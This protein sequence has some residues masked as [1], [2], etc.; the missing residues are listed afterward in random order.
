M[1]ARL[2]ALVFVAGVIFCVRLAVAQELTPV[3][4]SSTLSPSTRD[5]LTKE[6]VKAL[7]EIPT[8]GTA[9]TQKE[10]RALLSDLLAKLNVETTC[11][12]QAAVASAEENKDAQ[13][14]TCSHTMCE[15]ST[16]IDEAIAKIPAAETN[17]NQVKKRNDLQELKSELKK[18][19]TC[20]DFQKIS[21]RFD[22][23]TGRVFIR[24]V[25]NAPRSPFDTPS[26]TIGAK[27]ITLGLSGTDAFN[28]EVSAA[29]A[30][31]YNIGT[32]PD[33][34]K[35]KGPLTRKFYCTACSEY[36]F[37]F[38]A[39]YDD[40][41]KAAPSTP[42]AAN[43]SN[44][45]QQYSGE[46]MQ[47]SNLFHAHTIILGSAYHD[48]SQGVRYDVEPG[49][50]VYFRWNGKPVKGDDKSTSPKDGQATS[51]QATTSP[52][53]LKYQAILGLSGVANIDV[54]Y[55]NAQ[56][57]TLGGLNT[58]LLLKYTSDNARNTV[59]FN[60]RGF[61]P[62]IETMANGHAGAIFT[63]DFKLTKDKK[64]SL[65]FSVLD[66]YYSTVPASYSHNS[67]TPTL[68]IKFTQ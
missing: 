64:W 53:P 68:G 28:R 55:G 8:T 66:S 60:L 35:F 10:M 51:T 11:A 2:I 49:F 38:K 3:C 50:G 37:N 40:K 56:A 34:G 44:L 29:V 25:P 1:K 52:Q 67:L 5:S 12:N 23:I 33:G 43:L 27:S 31:Q 24:F 48:N 18:A 26:T 54:Q 65:S 47:L 20:D 39:N 62:A 21:D 15:L 32:Q 42:G 45:T 4:T 58:Y 63:D 57:A 59:G 46:V 14:T 22:K 7:A 19:K 36:I 61:L 41:W 6:V 16:N 13:Q 9:P 30:I 17:P